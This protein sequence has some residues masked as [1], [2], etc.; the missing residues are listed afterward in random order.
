MIQNI[1]IRLEHPTDYAEV[2]RLTL[3]A[4][5]T[6]EAE[7]V[8]KREIPNEHYLVHLLRDDPAFVPELD[9]VAELDSELVGNIM[10]S[11]CDIHRSDDS[12]TEALVFGPVSVLPEYQRQGIG[13][14]L[15][16]HS[17]ARAREFGYGAVIITGHVAYYPKFGF[18]PARRFGLTMPDGSAFDAFMALELREGYL[19]NAGGIWKCCAAFDIV[20]KDEEA[21]QAYHREFL[22]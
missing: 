2:E 22:R 13:A 11:K 15:V 7:G 1:S 19:G 17:L 9:F 3:A 4:F 20:E 8:P 5:E 14:R 16:E 12:V 6:F 18:V 21:F 10:Y